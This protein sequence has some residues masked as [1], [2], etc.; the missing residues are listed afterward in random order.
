MLKLV[1]PG[2]A[3]V[4]ASL[5]ASSAG[6]S[7]CDYRLSNLVGGQA[8]GATEATLAASATAG[9][10]LKAAGFYTLQH[11]AGGA[12]MLAS[13][14][15]GASAAGTVGIMGGTGQ[16]IGAAAAAL[17]APEVIAASAV[18]SVGAVGL[19][20]VCWVVGVPEGRITDLQ[21]VYA[22]VTYATE[23]L[24]SPDFVLVNLGDDISTAYLVIGAKRGAPQAVLVSDLCLLNGVLMIK[25][26]T[27]DIVLLDTKSL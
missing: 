12:T 10:A 13:T 21:T 1:R 4:L 9:A 7:T 8:T 5:L 20:A 23:K 3:F 11:S 26:I 16:G 22:T 24:N 14:A 27:G 17:M 25:M 15:G 2:M 19:E 6:A 18:V